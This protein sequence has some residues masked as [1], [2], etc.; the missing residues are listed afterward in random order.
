VIRRLLRWSFR[1]AAVS[2]ALIAA[3][4]TVTLA[5]VWLASRRDEA[6]PVQAIV[7]LGAAQYDGR[8]SPDLRARLDHV[9]LL[10][11]RHLAQV[12]VVTG[13]RLPGD[14]FTEATASANYLEARGVPDASIL[15]EVE[16]RSSWESLEAS[17]RFLQ[18]RGI[19]NIVLVSDPFHSERLLAMSDELGLHGH[20]SPTRTSPIRGVAVLPYFAK[21]TIAVGIGRVVG[22]RRLLSIERNFSP[23]GL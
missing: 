1:L 20:T 13:G 2:A 5:Q 16:G 17:A 11:Q 19:T 14:R 15:R 12:V 4:L 7:V 8:P 21:E 18:Q 9:V 3:Y 22:F 23:F 10:W 6:R